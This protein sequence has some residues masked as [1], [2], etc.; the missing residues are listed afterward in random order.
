MDGRMADTLRAQRMLTI[1]EIAALTRAKPRAG[2]PLDRCISNIAPL[3]TAVAVDISFLD[4]LRYLDALAITRAG[5]CFV[6]ERPL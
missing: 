5:A 4:K 6:A 1:E 2:D 3:D